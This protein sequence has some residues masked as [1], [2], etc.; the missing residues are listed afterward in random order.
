MS[1]IQDGNG[2]P[3]SNKGTRGENRDFLLPSFFFFFFSVMQIRTL[4]FVRGKAHFG[5]IFFWDKHF[6]QKWSLWTFF[7][8]LLKN[9][10]ICKA[11]KKKKI[12]VQCWFH[13]YSV[14]ESG[15]NTYSGTRIF[16]LEQS[17]AF[18]SHQAIIATVWTEK[19]QNRMNPI[20]QVDGQN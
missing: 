11:K 17:K 8:F 15:W 18:P 13:S 16:L 14:G 2:T 4:G 3:M 1:K 7:F 20:F 9:P 19:W 5:G 12:I 6:L 10:L